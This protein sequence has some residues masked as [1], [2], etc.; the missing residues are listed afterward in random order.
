MAAGDESRTKILRT[1]CYRHVSHETV[2]GV[3][4]GLSEVLG[5][6]IVRPMPRGIQAVGKASAAAS[7]PKT[8]K[9]R[10]SLLMVAMG[11]HRIAEYAA[12]WRAATGR[13][14]VW[15]FDA[16]PSTYREIDELTKKYEID[17]LF[18]TAKQSAERLDRTLG[19]VD[20]KWCPEPLVELG[21][22]N[23]PWAERKIGVLQIG[24][25]HEGFH[26]AL[27]G[28]RTPIGAKY[29]YEERQG[30]IIFP[31]RT[32]FVLGLA[33][34]KI[35]VCFPC[36][37]THA[38]RAG[39]VSTMTQRYLQSMASGCLVVGASPPE[40]VELFGYD[41]V[42][43]AEMDYP[44]AQIAEILAYPDKYQELVMKN[45]VEV[46]RHTVAERAKIIATEMG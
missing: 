45:L 23:K 5:W 16:W 46:K 37:M 20:V 29:L 35:S 31:T 22:K 19:G 3:E 4:D 10:R 9:R 17:V 43:P 21:F 39:D 30:E 42:V 44:A 25:K 12:D 15:L 8:I 40:M 13:R 28:S 26:R 2:Q 18:V 1:R 24:R 38:D 11:A 14:G 27:V 33:D 34:S 32:E 6:Q 41:P 7:L 36:D